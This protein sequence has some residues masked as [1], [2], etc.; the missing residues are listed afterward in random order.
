MLQ[1]Y[2]QKSKSTLLVSIIMYL[3]LNL[4]LLMLSPLRQL[5]F[6]PFIHSNTVSNGTHFVI[7]LT[8]KKL[9]KLIW[10]KKTTTK[11][12]CK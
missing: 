2:F 5:I 4:A 6:L 8:F 12:D 9:K 10:E 7:K 1:F 3:V 11:T